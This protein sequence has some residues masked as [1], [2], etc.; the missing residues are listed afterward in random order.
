MRRSS[1][2]P[3]TSSRASS[4]SIGST[5]QCRV[6]GSTCMELIGAVGGVSF[7]IVS[8]VIGLRLL[9]L[10]RRT[11]ELPEF[12]IGLALFLMGGLGYPLVSV[13][14]LA[15]G[16]PEG[17]R[18]SLFL[19]AILFNF[20][21]T[22]AICVFNRRV[23]RP[24]DAWAHWLTVAFACSLA[25]AL[26]LQSVTPGLPAAALYDDGAGYHLFMTFQGVPI[27]WAAFES[28]RYYRLVKRRAQLGLAD[29]MVVNR[30]FLWGV[31]MLSAFVINLFSSVLAF[32]GIDIATSAPGALVVAPL[33]LVAAGCVW[34][35]FLPPAAYT[36]RFSPRAATDKT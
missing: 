34:L 26:A 11:R 27:A 6:R 23:F 33:G 17:A 4:P 13:A 18:T 2:L 36:R 21:G 9:L 19:A 24:R 1:L 20:I 5:A 32:I 3:A 30:I 22:G 10:A 28:L 31:A 16:M 15:H 7:I 8:L 29:P 35:A 14:R 12:A 25:G